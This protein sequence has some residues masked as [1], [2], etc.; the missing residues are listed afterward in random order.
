MK[1]FGVHF[2]YN[3]NLK[4]DKNFCEQIVKIENILK[5]RHM[6]QLTLEGRITVLKYLA[7]SNVM[8]LLLITKLLDNTVD[9][10]HK[11]QKNF[12]WQGEK[13]KIKHSTLC[14]GYEI[15]GIK[16]VDLRNKM[17]SMQC[18]WVKRL[19]DDDFHDW[20]IPPLF[21]IGKHLGKN[22][23]FHNNIVKSNGI[24]SKFPSFYQDIFIKWINNFTSKSTLQSMILSEVICFNSNIKV[25]SKPVRFSFFSDQNLNFIGELVNDIPL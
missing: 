9:L 8:H 19:F 17:T 21:L 4:Q 20:K 6:R 10:L 16:N 7:I 11:I 13:A 12:N 2:S 1:I 14:N 24:P 3:K 23:K 18:S 15:V 25:G 22:F 5:L